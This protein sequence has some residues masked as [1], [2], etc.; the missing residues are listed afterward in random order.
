MVPLTTAIGRQQSASRC[1][2]YG[3]ISCD[4]PC[5]RSRPLADSSPILD[6][7][8]TDSIELA[9]V[10]CNDHL[11]SR[12]PGSSYQDIVSS[13]WLPLH[14]ERRANCCGGLRIRFIKRQRGDSREK[15]RQDRCQL[16]RALVVKRQALINFHA[17]KRRYDDQVRRCGFDSCQHFCLALDKIKDRADVK[18]ILQSSGSDT[19][20]LRL[21]LLAS[22][23]G[24]SPRP[25]KASSSSGHCGLPCRCSHSLTAWRTSVF[26]LLPTFLA[27]LLRC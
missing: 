10:G 14:L 13:C 17:R 4:A 22:N 21:S 20:G 11:A 15:R 24:M 3:D 8:S 12:Q 19:G 9:H 7:Q 27:T 26:R 25:W 5:V 16:L 6:P 23:G 2:R 18:Q 1:W